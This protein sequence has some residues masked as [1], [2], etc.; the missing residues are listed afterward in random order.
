MFLF[1][2]PLI[3]LLLQPGHTAA[4]VGA[5][6]PVSG[7]PCPTIGETMC[8]DKTTQL[9]CEGNKWW[10]IDCATKC[11]D[12]TCDALAD[13]Q[14]EKRLEILFAKAKA[15][16]LVRRYG[17]GGGGSYN[18]DGGK[19]RVTRAQFDTAV[20]SAGYPCPSLAKYNAFVKVAIDQGHI[21]CKREL[22]M[23]LTQVLWESDGLRAKEEYKCKLDG[24][25]DEY[26]F[27]DL[28][29]PGKKYFGRGY[30]QLTWSYNYKACSHDLYHNDKLLRHPGSV[31][32]SEELSWATAAWYWKK[33]VHHVAKCGLF[34]RT[35]RAINGALECGKGPNVK[36]A[37][38][39]FRMY[40]KVFKAFQLP[41][42]P[43]EGGC[44]N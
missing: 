37:R 12:N 30:I 13:K 31:A 36:K 39:R 10:A 28:D 41:G 34:G 23:F 20:K 16:H 44:Y 32:R 42:V 15:P 6:P 8:K 29:Q 26:H 24:C 17:G 33:N 7:A 19:P 25:D 2:L 43:L 18:T 35:T 22:A 38:M 3:V 14:V 9:V 5:T 21:S 40:K 11:V 4:A 27:P 1:S